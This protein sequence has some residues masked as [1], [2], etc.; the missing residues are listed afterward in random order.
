MNALVVFSAVRTTARH[1]GSAC[2][3]CR[4]TDSRVI[5]CAVV[6]ERNADVILPT[7]KA[8]VDTAIVSP[9]GGTSTLGS[10]P[11][12]GACNIIPHIDDD[13]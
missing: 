12:L 3:C 10:W 8:R 5:I 7:T 4:S 1:A 11:L 2:L 6:V 13:R 9:T